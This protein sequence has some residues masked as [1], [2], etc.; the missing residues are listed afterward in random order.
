LQDQ[1]KVLEVQNATVE[2]SQVTEMQK[3]QRLLEKLQKVEIDTSIGQ[4]LAEAKETI[5]MNIID[6][7]NEIWPSIQIIFE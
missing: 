3:S 6:S 5:W 7:M 2:T 1:L 4:T